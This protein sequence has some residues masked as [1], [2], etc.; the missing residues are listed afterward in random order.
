MQNLSLLLSD[1]GDGIMFAQYFKASPEVNAE[2]FRCFTERE[3]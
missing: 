3:R 2:W 1:D